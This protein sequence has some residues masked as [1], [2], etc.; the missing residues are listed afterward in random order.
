MPMNMQQNNKPN[1]AANSNKPTKPGAK[2]NKTPKQQNTN[3]SNDG[4]GEYISVKDWVILMVMLAIPI[5][6]IVVLIKGIKNPMT[7]PIKKNYLVAF[8]VY[9]IGSFILSVIIAVILNSTGAIYSL[10]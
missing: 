1:Q 2:L 10:V 3:T 9:A 6:N 8:A 5:V 7:L 4:L